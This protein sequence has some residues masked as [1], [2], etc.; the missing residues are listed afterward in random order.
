MG[1]CSSN[2]CDDLPP[3]PQVKPSN[4]KLRVVLQPL[5]LNKL[6]NQ[7]VSPATFYAKNHLATSFQ[8]SDLQ[9]LQKDV[10]RSS[11]KTVDSLSDVGVE[12]SRK[13]DKDWKNRKTFTTVS[14]TS[15]SD[16]EGDNLSLSAKSAG[17][18]IFN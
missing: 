15:D 12:L 7:R 1:L 5:S 16:K 4:N 9:N 13:S 11:D 10:A 2:S 8:L 3:L 17:T 14:T 18:D 6:Y